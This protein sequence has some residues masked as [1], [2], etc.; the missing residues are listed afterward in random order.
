MIRHTAEEQ[1]Q[2]I[3]LLAQ[4]VSLRPRRFKNPPPEVSSGR[5]E[6][7]EGRSRSRAHSSSHGHSHG[8]VAEGP[9]VLSVSGSRTSGIYTERESTDS[10]SSHIGSSHFCSNTMLFIS[11]REDLVFVWFCSFSSRR[12]MGKNRKWVLEDSI[13]DAVWKTHFARASFTLGP[14][15]KGAQSVS[16][17]QSQEGVEVEG[18]RGDA[19]GEM[20][21]RQKLCPLSH[22]DQF[23]KVHQRC[24]RQ[25]TPRSQGCRHGRERESCEVSATCASSRSSRRRDSSSGRGR[26]W[27]PQ[28]RQF[29][30]LSRTGTR[31][32]KH[33]HRGKSVSR[34]PFA[35][36]VADAETELARLRAQVAEL[37]GSTRGV[38]RPRARVSPAEMPCLIP[39]ELSAWMEDQSEG[40]AGSPQ[41][42]RPQSSHRVE[43]DVDNESRAYGRN[44]QAGNFRR[45]VS[46]SHSPWRGA[47][48]TLLSTARYGHRGTR[49]GEAAHP[50]PNSP[51]EKG[52]G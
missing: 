12:L 39:A 19:S 38:E 9:T 2:S 5:T 43:F 7:K 42:G 18:H 49:V 31:V 6:R 28:R 30:L 27:L 36:P 4:A 20:P 21:V 22:N 13:Q 35:G 44:D 16:R 10:G 33:W 24:M 32:S 29:R 46:V 23:V 11:R 14:L 48:R 26:D 8:E 51:I 52:G 47:V 15:G 45:R 41:H 37:Q 50:G 3:D 1:R 34:S 25:L 17:C 40:H